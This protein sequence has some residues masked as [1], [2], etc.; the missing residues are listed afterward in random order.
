MVARVRPPAWHRHWTVRDVVRPGTG[1]IR[2]VGVCTELSQRSGL[3]PGQVPLL[4]STIGRSGR[5]GLLTVGCRGQAVEPYSAFRLGPVSDRAK[6]QFRWAVGR[7][8]WR[9]QEEDRPQVG[10]VVVGHGGEHREH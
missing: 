5:S 6:R 10:S 1:Q 9:L 8:G 3:R 4:G 7:V 2:L